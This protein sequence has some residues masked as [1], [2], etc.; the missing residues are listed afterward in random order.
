MSMPIGGP[1]PPHP[2]HVPE[3]T[4]ANTWTAQLLDIEDLVKNG[5][6][7]GALNKIDALIILLNAHRPQTNKIQAAVQDLYDARAHL[8]GGD[9]IGKIM[10]NLQDAIK[11]L[12]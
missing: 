6:T 3:N 7:T 10:K 5:N 8:N 4:P 11:W 9:P 12:S 1:T 2:Y